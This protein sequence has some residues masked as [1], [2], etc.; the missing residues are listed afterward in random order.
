MLFM[1]N[2][3]IDLM[4]N[5]LAA[6]PDIRSAIS[7]LQQ[8]TIV[9]YELSNGPDGQ[10]VYWTSSYA[11]DEFRLSLAP[12]SRPADITHRADWAQMVRAAK[13]NREGRQ[14]ETEVQTIG[15]QQAFARVAH[16]F[17]LGRQVATVDCEF[18]D[19]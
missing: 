9:T 7:K 18:P 10:T 1:S 13:A 19:V 4:N 17:E 11:P 15:D 3:H 12:P 5:L 16:I 6:S 8:E 14:V 2:E